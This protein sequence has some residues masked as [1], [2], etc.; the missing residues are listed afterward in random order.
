MPRY[1][2]RCAECEKVFQISHSMSERYET[3][4]ECCADCDCPGAVEKIP[5][6]P[7]ILSRSYDAGA[8]SRVRRH[9]EEAREEIAREIEHVRNKENEL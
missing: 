2:Y 4:A 8:G 5:A 3:C 9:I 6:M 1:I 7:S